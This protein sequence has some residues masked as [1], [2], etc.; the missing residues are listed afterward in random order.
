MSDQEKDQEA[1]QM[2][3]ASELEWTGKME[4]ATMKEMHLRSSEYLQNK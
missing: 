3:A 1:A 4:V 2:A